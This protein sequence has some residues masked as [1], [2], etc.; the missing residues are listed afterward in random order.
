MF[1][2]RDSVNYEYHCSL[3]T[4]VLCESDSVIYGI[5]YKSTL[6]QLDN[7]NVGNGQLPQDV[8]HILLEGVLPYTIKA[9]LQSFV[10]EKRFFTIEI[11]NQKISSFRYSRSESK[12]K[13]SQIS[14]SVLTDDG[15]ISQ[16]GMLLCDKN[17]MIIIHPC[18][19]YKCSQPNVESISIFTIDDWRPGA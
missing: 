19:Y 16:S 10:C 18:I 11:L 4:G 5:N 12:N 6:N 8:M 2:L 17:L 7:F 9:M 15:T 14:S 1:V 3:L 13:P